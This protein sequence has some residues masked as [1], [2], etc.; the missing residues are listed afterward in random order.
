M[1]AALRSQMRLMDCIM[2]E[3]PQEWIL[4][5]VALATI[6]VEATVRCDIR[7][8]TDYMDSVVCVLCIMMP[9]ACWLS[10]YAGMGW[11]GMIT[12]RLISRRR[13]INQDH[14]NNGRV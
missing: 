14:N 12:R 1:C 3:M 4:C 7:T 10:S 13:D 6:A 8:V 5:C 2:L 11:Y 9:F